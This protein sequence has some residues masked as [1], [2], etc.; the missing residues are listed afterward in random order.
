[1]NTLYLDCATGISGDMTVAALIDLGLELDVLRRAVASLNIVDVEISTREVLKEGFRAVHFQVNHPPQ[2]VHRTFADI[3]TI[4]EG[5][6][7]LT[8]TQKQL[9]LE[10]FA[11][12][13][14][15]EGA[16]HGKPIEEVHFHEVGA[17]D[18]IVDIVCTAVGFDLL[19]V[20]RVISSP[21]PTGHGQVKIAHGLCSIPTPGTAELL[22][23]I[24]LIDVP[25]EA[26]LTTP[27]GAAILA[28]LVHE[29]GNLPALTIEKIGYGAG[30]RDIPG[31]ANMLRMFLGRSEASPERDLVTLLET[32]LDDVSGEIIGHASERLRE[33]GA[34]DVYSTPIQMKKNRPGVLLSVLSRPAD[35]DR[36]EEIVFRE[37]G[38]FGIRRR[39][40]ER[41]KRRRRE[42]SV[43]TPFG[44]IRGKL[45]WREGEAAVFMPEFEDCARVA[46]EAGVP[47]REV[48]GAAVRGWPDDRP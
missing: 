16:V 3:R 9:A 23:G 48:Y 31:R 33:S 39:T 24:P 46:A 21:V 8:D 7:A 2:H 4:I 14:R 42:T 43:D 18:S 20:D 30:T 15:A 1:M 47:L 32:N 40:L 11:A 35:A 19:K 27:T 37:T 17:I 6:S 5:A 44:P 38:T 10:I 45:G 12:V 26:E 28:T 25:V 34:L 29:F 36:L 22:K 13:A 41:S